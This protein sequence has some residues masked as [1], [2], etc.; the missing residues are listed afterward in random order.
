MSNLKIKAVGI[1]DNFI[2]NGVSIMTPSNIYG[3]T[4]HDNCMIGPFVEIQHDVE[5]GKYTRV[6]SHCFI[7][8]YAKIGDNCFIGHGTMFISDDFKMGYAT[9]ENVKSSYIGNNVTIGNNATIFPVK[10]CDGC[11]IGAGAVVTKDITVKGTY[12]GN[13]AKMLKAL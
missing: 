4:L 5:I 11:I 9:I 2:G 3:A 10:I 13:P 7:P 8:E 1:V 6:Q 12:A